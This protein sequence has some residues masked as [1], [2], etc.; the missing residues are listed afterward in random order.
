MSFLSLPY[1]KLLIILSVIVYNETYGST[2]G[3]K[4]VNKFKNV[5]FSQF[6]NV[7]IKKKFVKVR[8]Q[9]KL[10][11]LFAKALMFFLGMPR[12]IARRTH[13]V[14][15]SLKQAD[16]TN[17]SQIEDVR[18]YYRSHVITS[19]ELL[20]GLEKQCVFN[21]CDLRTGDLKPLSRSKQ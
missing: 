10:S 18:L 11:M 16:L 4:N 5:L 19:V 15:R 13:S 1:S 12:S 17:R 6:Q 7:Q 8:W 3:I 2:Y 20:R 14:T 9:E 21:P